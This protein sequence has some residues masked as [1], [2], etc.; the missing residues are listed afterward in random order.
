MIVP[1]SSAFRRS[2]PPVDG[3]DGADRLQ[4]EVA[5]RQPGE[6]EQ[7]AELG[8]VVLDLAVLDVEADGVR[9]R[10]GVDAGAE[11]AVAEER[12]LIPLPGETRPQEILVAQE[13]APAARAVQ[14]VPYVWLE[15]LATLGVRAVV[16]FSGDRGHGGE[17]SGSPSNG[18]TSEESTA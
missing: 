14:P 17:K 13:L 1:V 2:Q 3:G 10:L 16:R 4:R 8:A 11:A 18:E 5:D 15:A 7:R 6:S 12:P 9:A